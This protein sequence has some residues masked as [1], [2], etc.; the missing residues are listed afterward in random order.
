MRVDIRLGSF[1]SPRHFRAIKVRLYPTSR[2]R[3][4]MPLHQFQEPPQ[5]PVVFNQTPT[6]L[7]DLTQTTIAISRAT[8]DALVRIPP[9]EATFANFVLPWIHDRN[10]R[11]KTSSLTALFKS[12]SPSQELRDASIECVKMWSEFGQEIVARPEIYVLFQA[13]KE[14]GEVLDQEEQYYLDRKISQLVRSGAALQEG[15]IKE[16][17]QIVT[18]RID[19]IE[20]EGGKRIRQESGGIWFTAEELGGFPRDALETLKKGEGENEGKYKVTF[21]TVDLD[22]ASKNCVCS[23]TRKRMFFGNES[24]CP[25]N[26]PLFQEMI[27]LRAEHAELLGYKYHADLV[28][29][30]RLMTMEGVA[31]LLVDLQQKT[32]PA[33]ESSRDKLRKLKREHLISQEIAEIDIDDRLYLWDQ[34]FYMRLME[35]QESSL[36]QNKIAEFFPLQETIDGLLTNFETLFGVVFNEI[37]EDSRRILMEKQG[38]DASAITWH[39]DVAAYAVWNE[40]ALGGDFL[41]YL[42]LDVLKRQGKRDHAC[43]I[44]FQPGFDTI[45]GGQQYPSAVLVMSIQ[46]PTPTKPTLVRHRNV[47]TMFH[48]LGHGIHCLVGRTRYGET[49]GT[50]TSRDFVEIPSRMLENFCWDPIILQNLSKHYAYLSPE[51]MAS[52]KAENPKLSEPPEKAP[53]EHLEKLGASRK[54]TLAPL[55]Q[56]Q[57]AF[58]KFD[59]A[60]H[61]ISNEEAKAMNPGET[62]NRIRKE[63]TGLLGPE[64]ESGGF[65]WGCGHSRFSHM[66]GGYDA[67][68][69]TYVM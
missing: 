36:D 37:S 57:I 47:V 34:L 24:K 28:I 1:T 14:K 41:G 59:M 26:V 11:M 66:F 10:N 67:G 30:D 40:E 63:C 22:L 25:D 49:Y 53:L 44:T 43:C 17:F 69:Y 31:D 29:Q 27:E 58:A 38:Q 33:S 42:Y 12:V 54:V 64:I 35:E 65:G 9:S 7:I 18:K 68:Y 4:K 51:Y 13:V 21:G 45:D 2:P 52:W 60:I 55:T 5:L 32:A 3:F 39:E 61:S 46:R 50:K 56:R 16:R 8:L 48:E 19:D 15:P 6:G 62:Y 23:D 20:S